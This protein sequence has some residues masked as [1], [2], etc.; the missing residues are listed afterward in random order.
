MAHLACPV[1]VCVAVQPLGGLP[2]SALSKLTVSGAP[3]A[4]SAPIRIVVL[5]MSDPLVRS[6]QFVQQLLY[7]S[8]DRVAHGSIP[9]IV[10]HVGPI[11]C[12]T[13]SNGL[14]WKSAADG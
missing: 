10:W 4:S 11:G 7:M 6:L 12:F 9:L 1:P 13:R 5:L 14:L 2:T 8:H 3:A